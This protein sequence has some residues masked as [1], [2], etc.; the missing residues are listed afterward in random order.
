MHH[1]VQL[2]DQRAPRSTL[3]RSTK[4]PPTAEQ[5]A[6]YTSPVGFL[7]KESKRTGRA[8]AQLGTHL[9]SR[10]ATYGKPEFTTNSESY[11]PSGEPGTAVA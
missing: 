4:T 3:E 7:G 8:W 2:D 5:V 10:L 9:K 1:S 11:H 6:T